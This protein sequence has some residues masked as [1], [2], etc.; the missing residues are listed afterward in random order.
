MQ[1]TSGLDWLMNLR[2]ANAAEVQQALIGLPG[3]GRKV[4]DCVAVFSL[5]QTSAVPVD[6][7]VWSIACRDMDASLQVRGGVHSHM[8]SP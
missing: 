8:Y 7:H 1:Q 4:A 2:K 5:D 6:T 3:V